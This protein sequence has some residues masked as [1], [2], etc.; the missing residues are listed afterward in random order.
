METNR[1]LRCGHE[2]L[3]RKLDRSLTCPKCRSPYWDIPRRKNE[4]R[5]HP[6]VSE[7]DK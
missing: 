4:K 7:I 6:N 5:V 3:P 2:W 1:C